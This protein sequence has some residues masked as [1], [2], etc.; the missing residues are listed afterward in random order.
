MK[1]NSAITFVISPLLMLLVFALPARAADHYWHSFRELVDSAGIPTDVELQQRSPRKKLKMRTGDYRM[2]CHDRLTKKDIQSCRFV[3]TG[4]HLFI[5]LK[6]LQ[7]EDVPFRGDFCY[8]MRIDSA[9]VAFLAPRMNNAIYGSQPVVGDAVLDA[10]IGGNQEYTYD[11]YTNKFEGQSFGV[12]L[13]NDL[14]GFSRDKHAYKKKIAADRTLYLYSL[15][16]STQVHIIT[17]EI[18]SS[19]LRDHVDLMTEYWKLEP[20][21]Q[22]APNVMAAFIA[23]AIKERKKG[24]K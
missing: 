22:S 16:D 20:R 10:A 3:T 19:L 7:T 13:I 8:C 21:Y 5:N 23:R 18:L 24:D 12:R 14:I 11:P 2:K 17:P 15:T 1:I 4:G 6:G 9:N